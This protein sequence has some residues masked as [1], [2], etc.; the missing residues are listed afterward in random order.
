MTTITWIVIIAGAAALAQ[1][2]MRLV[3]AIDK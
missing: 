2:I 3:E 1:G